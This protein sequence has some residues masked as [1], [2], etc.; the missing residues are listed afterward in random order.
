MERFPSS[1]LPEMEK[2]SEDVDFKWT[3]N[4]LYLID[5]T[6]FGTEHVQRCH[7]A[8]HATP[9]SHAIAFFEHQIMTV[10]GISWNIPLINQPW[11]TNPYK[12]SEEVISTTSNGWEMLGRPSLTTSGGFSSDVAAVLW[13][14]FGYPPVS[15]NMEIY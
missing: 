10:G 13:Q 5:F 6:R 2:R 11:L 4:G 8:R 7:S 14:H 15:S 12:P 9:A 3:S 1:A